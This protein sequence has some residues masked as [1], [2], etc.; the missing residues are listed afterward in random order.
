MTSMGRAV[1][2]VLAASL[3]AYAGCPS[4]GSDPCSGI[5]CSS[6]GFCI[7]DQ[8]T[9][10]C[11]CLLG[12]HPSRLACEPNDPDEPC[13]GIE[14]SGHGTCRSS[15]DEVWCDCDPGYRPLL[16]GEADCAEVDCD[17]LCL[18]RP[19]MDG[20]PETEDAGGGDGEEADA[21][22]AADEGRDGAED[23]PPP[24]CR[25]GVLEDG[26]ECDDGNATSLDG[27]EP[28][29]RFTCHTA[30]ECADGDPCTRDL[31]E[32]AGGGRLCRNPVDVGAACDD[33]NPCTTGETCDDTGA[34]RGGTGT[35]DCT[36]TADC[37]EYE[38]G[39]LRNGTLICDPGSH[40]CIVDPE[41][42]VT[43][44]PSADTACRRNRCVPATGTCVPTNEPDGTVCNDGLFCTLTDS[45]RGGV[46]T[47]SGSPCPSGPCAAPCDEAGDRCPLLGGATELSCRS[48][49]GTCDVEEFCTGTSAS[50]P[51]DGFRPS[52]AV[53]R[54]ALAACDVAETCTGSSAV[55]PADA[56]RPSGYVC[57][58][59]T[60][61]CDVAEAC[62]GLGTI[63]PADALR[64]SGYTCR[65][66]A[67]P[68]DIAEVCS[69]TSANCPANVL[70]PSGY[71]CRF[72]AGACDIAETC[73]GSSPACPLD[74]FLP[75]GYECRRSMTDCDPAEV[76]SGTSVSCPANAFLPD[77]TECND[78]DP[79]TG[80]DACLAGDC[81]AYVPP[82]V[83]DGADN[84]CD[85]AVDEGVSCTDFDAA[86]VCPGSYGW[87]YEGCTGQCRRCLCEPAL[88]WGTC[89]AC[90]A[91]PG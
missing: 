23:V 40:T 48:A 71:A 11:V 8:D 89:A 62:S 27:C 24:E 86:P 30:D 61:D 55:C 2:M 52:T 29:C 34:C 38:D 78:H 13:H 21:T 82:E 12:Y 31:C 75:A 28:D 51:P 18:P 47:G 69:G 76:C 77:G 53:C 67:G 68:C 4:N 79:C 88:T 85:T 44:D 64:P 70:R 6:R 80:P 46:C 25:N 37:A 20:G 56:Y 90:G 17:L 49:A 14:C 63:C 19:P 58:A 54:G 91:C 72:Q 74:A 60:G 35:C 9:P 26:E 36:V 10:Y 83:C 22:D 1:T 66:V 33:G 50:C 57:R 59:S 42:I 45:C 15:G 41:T 87:T 5:N 84:D 65:A 39:N 3:P 16:P 43:C 73:T 7:E 32:A 81:V